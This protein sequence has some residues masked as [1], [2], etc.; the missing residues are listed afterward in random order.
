MS[1]RSGLYPQV[2]VDAATVPAVAHA[3]G[4]LLTRTVGVS[5]LGVA[6]SE[7]LRPWRKPVARHDPAKVVTRPGRLVGVGWGRLPRRIAVAGRTGRVRGGGLGC[8]DQPVNLALEKAL[9]ITRGHRWPGRGRPFGAHICAH[10]KTAHNRPRFT[11]C[12]FFASAG[13]A[14]REP[15]RHRGETI[16]RYLIGSESQCDR[17]S[18]PAMPNT[19]DERT[20]SAGR[21][22]E[23]DSSIRRLAA[24]LRRA[25]RPD[26]PQTL[27]TPTAHEVM[28]P[29]TSRREPRGAPSRRRPPM[30]H[31]CRR[32]NAPRLTSRRYLDLLILTSTLCCKRL[33]QRRN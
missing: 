10:E 15:S 33:L 28:Y 26:T 30:P 22:R 4:A 20:R 29:I 14:D 5:G 31:S 16:P 9:W 21:G 17:A 13:T 3:G 1:K 7:A 6:L 32:P 19:T 25:S 12:G 24:R 23:L 18:R 8:D 2:R 27:A 11:G